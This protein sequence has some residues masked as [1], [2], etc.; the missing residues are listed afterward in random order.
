MT[1]SRTATCVG[2]PL[3]GQT[4]TSRFPRGVLVVNRPAGEAVVYDFNGITFVA[5]N[6]G[7]PELELTSG[8]KNRYRAALE[9]NYDV[10]A[11]GAAGLEW[12]PWGR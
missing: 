4:F 1:T 3:D 9:P 11:Y 10:V 12:A 5:R 8:P 7:R 6:G 2:G